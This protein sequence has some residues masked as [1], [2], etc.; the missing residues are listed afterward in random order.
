[1]KLNRSNFLKTRSWSPSGKP[2]PVSITFTR[3]SSDPA[4]SVSKVKVPPALLYL[5]A[6]DNKLISDWVACR[7][8]T[9]IFG[10]VSSTAET[11]VTSSP[12]VSA[13]VSC[14]HWINQSELFTVLRLN[15]ICPDS[16]RLIS[17]S[18]LTMASKCRA[19][20]KISLKLSSW[21]SVR[22]CSMSLCRSWEKPMMAFSG[23]R[24][25]WL[26][27]ERKLDFS[28]LAN[29]AFCTSSLRCCSSYNFFKKP[30]HIS[31]P[32]PRHLHFNSAQVLLGSVPKEIPT[33]RPA[34][35]LCT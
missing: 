30:N 12:E 19:P 15:F 5:I 6:V 4:W 9:S 28:L 35:C 7:A 18:S 22:G 17:R 24:N 27:E 14:K 11:T 33:P 8:S 26:I 25:S 34:S 10:R 20:C 32:L 1:V 13:A 21:S 29:S 16:I 23:V 31:V 2:T 3:I